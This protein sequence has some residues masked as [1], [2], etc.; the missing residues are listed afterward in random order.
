[1]APLR[2]SQFQSH[3]KW[4]YEWAEDENQRP[5]A[6]LCVML[7]KT[8]QRLVRLVPHMMGQNDFFGG[9]KFQHY[10]VEKDM[11]Y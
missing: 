8:S 1:M 9:G 11:E 10:T 7:I 3:R 6:I 2:Y 4:R 5:E